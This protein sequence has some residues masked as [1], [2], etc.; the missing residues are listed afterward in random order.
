MAGNR[1]MIDNLF[2]TAK[3][4]HFCFLNIFCGPLKIFRMNQFVPQTSSNEN[5]EI[6]LWRD[7]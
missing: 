1:K 4:F 5:E 6:C 2:Q 7:D 3:L